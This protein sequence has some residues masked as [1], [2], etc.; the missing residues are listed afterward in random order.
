MYGWFMNV[1]VELIYATSW[2]FSFWKHRKSGHCIGG[3]YVV[4]SMYC[5]VYYWNS[6]NVVNMIVFGLDS[7]LAWIP[8]L[9]TY[10]FCLG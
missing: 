6:V 9:F 8:E 3:M 2:L 10:L 4:Y 1:Y 5:L 7:G